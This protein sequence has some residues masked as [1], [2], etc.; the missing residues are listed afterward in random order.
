TGTIGRRGAG[1]HALLHGESAPELVQ[2]YLHPVPRI[3][4]GLWLQ[5]Q[6]A[7]RAMI[8]LSDGLL[9]DARHIAT[10]SGIEIDLTPGGLPE[11]PLLAAYWRAR[12]RDAELE[13]L[14]SGEEYELLVAV[15]Q[16]AFASL[17]DAFQQQFN[18]PFS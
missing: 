18:L 16:S 4:E 7:V 15:E 6:T 13:R 1:L 12:E 14:R 8:D 2:D 3:Q 17:R 9:P 11:D 5:A 10:E